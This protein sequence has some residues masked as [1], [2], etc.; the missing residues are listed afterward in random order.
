M[1]TM[2]KLLLILILAA[3]MLAG[4]T[5]APAAQAA[6]VPSS[7]ASAEAAPASD[8]KADSG[9]ITIY[10]ALEDEQFSEGQETRRY[11]DVLPNVSK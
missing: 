2:T 3:A 9:E 5:A 4:C 10:T 1:K 7:S 6:P 11:K 8:N